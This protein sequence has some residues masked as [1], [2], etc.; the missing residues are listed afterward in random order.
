MKTPQ[1][2]HPELA[3][4]IGVGMLYLKREDLHPYGSHK[5]RSIPKMIYNYV[6][7][8]ATEFVISSSGNAA[9]AAMMTVRDYNAT[10]D[11]PLTL[12]VYV[13]NNIPAH[14]LAHLQSLTSSQITLDQ[15]ERPKQDAFQ[16]A[17]KSGTINLRQSTDDAALFGYHE[18]AFELTE[19]LHLSAV[20]IPTSSGTT[21]EG[22][23]EGF[24]ETDV[25]PQIHIAQTTSCHPIADASPSPMRGG[26]EGFDDVP[27][28][29]SL[30]TAIVDNVAHRKARIV[31]IM[32]ETH[33][34]GWIITNKEIK[35]AIALVKQ[36]TDIDISPNS[37]LSIAAAKKAV[38][39]GW[40][41]DGA[42]VCFV[43]G[44]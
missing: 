23:A 11:T 26:Q 40:E 27:E 21:A 30:A 2:S 1:S 34:N 13:G 37:A 31:E 18:L 16:A 22:V 33:G 3:K 4:A 15:V 12:T 44:E 19:I 42:V 14:K 41:F 6:R 7:D 38:E 28:E 39:S 8:S 29:T 25:T 32:K 9:L 10:A 35:Q 17:K 43:C 24:D 20:F 5:G 36:H